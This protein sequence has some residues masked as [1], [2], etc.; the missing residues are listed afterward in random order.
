MVLQLLARAAVEL[1]LQLSE[2][3]GD[4]GCVAVQNWGVACFDLPWMVQDYY[5]RQKQGLVETNQKSEAISS[6]SEPT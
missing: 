3:A 1:L 5:L 6:C 4:V 2:T